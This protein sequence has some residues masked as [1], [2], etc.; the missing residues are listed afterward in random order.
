M[1][2]DG[3]E[4]ARRS[5]AQAPGAARIRV[6]R[7]DDVL[8]L[9][10][11]YAERDVAAVRAIPGRRWE[12]QRGLWSLPATNGT[13]DALTRAFGPR[14][15]WEGGPGLIKA[16]EPTGRHTETRRESETILDRGPAHVLERIQKAIGARGYSPKT[17]SAYL[18]WTRRFLA[19][20]ASHRDGAGR[21]VGHRARAFL[22]H[23]ARERRLSART[24]NQAASALSFMFREVFGSDEL[25]D[26]PR[27]KGSRR[28]PTV[29]THREVLRVLRELSG[30]HL[31]IGAL[32]YSAGLR[33][34]EC[35]RLRV[36]DV[37]FELR[38]IAVRD[39]KG[40][41]DRYVPLARRATALLKTQLARIAELHKRDRAAGGGWAPLPAAL[42]RKDPTAGYQIAWQFL[43][44]ARTPGRD[45]ATGRSGRRP[46]HP[47]AVQKEIKRAVRRSGITKRA[48]SHTLRHSFATEALRGG[49]DIRTLQHVMGHK[50]VRTTMIYLHVVEH[51][52]LHIRSPLDRPDDSEE[53]DDELYDEPVGRPRLPDRDPDPA[54]RPTSPATAP[55][56]RK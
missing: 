11:R 44:P 28:M 9:R 41:K 55:R 16:P 14:I 29:L 13:I 46:V 47:T 54:L 32:L 1:E 6:T 52:G 39:G 26:V 31:L 48:S 38:Q 20:D 3:R 25:A 8:E 15:T 19:F 5:P 40:N 18:G 23:L 17:E 34:E 22:E 35:L 2:R 37:D 50:D 36:K 30:R 53:L 33:L 27:A 4:A 21:P 10:F 49:C 56:S 24:R 51:S 7:R 12:P 42:H 45:P 43:F